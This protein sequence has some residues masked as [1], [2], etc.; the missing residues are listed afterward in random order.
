MVGVIGRR[1]VLA[2]GG[3]AALGVLTSRGAGTA[4][5]VPA[6]P[7]AGT[8]RRA[9]A[10][11]DAMTRAH[12][13]P[14]EPRLP[15]SYADQVGLYTTGFTY[16][17][18]LAVLAF[19]ADGRRE[20]AE[21]ARL[22]GQ[23]L[24]YA[25]EH[26]PHHADGRLRQAY[27]VG[28]Y[29]RDGVEQPDGFVRPD[30]TVN[31]GGA[32]GFIGSGT[33]ECAW[34]GLALCALHDRFGDRGSL[35]AA[36]RLGEWIVDTCRSPGRL[37]GFTTGIDRD[38]ARSP[39]VSTA[40]NADVA[41]LFGRL[42]DLTGDR[43]W[44]AH[45]RAAARFVA[46]MWSPRERA[47]ASGAP[48]GATPEVLPIVLEAQTHPRLAFAGYGPS[49]GVHT[50]ARLLT[51]TD[52][53]RRPNSALARGRRFTGVTVSTASRT[54]DPAVPIEPG[55]PRPDPY[56]VWLEG[57]AQYV[58]AARRDPAGLLDAIV[59][60]RTLAEAQVRLGGGQTVAGRALP[61]GS[62]LVSATS[63][64]HVGYVDSG[65]YPVAHVGTTAWFV[66]AATGTDPLRFG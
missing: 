59:R 53:A 2:G 29:V 65:Y 40:H 57:T 42:A 47:F 51:V 37:G 62:G 46:A 18:A 13:R 11:L 52:T 55:L 19:L 1:A 56:A 45:R 36:V 60:L 31:V 34:A 48:D 15:Q 44:A 10:F 33:G 54:A 64:L 26:D 25:Q 35:A 21:S 32:F 39:R 16:D 8:R 22:L 61:A 49:L 58:L 63:P 43:A 50:A 24:V 5:A 27:T 12:G 6:G 23:A 17:A 66:L 7:P 9:V 28:P 38:G 20:S 3:A 41:A 4:Q 14:G 30:G